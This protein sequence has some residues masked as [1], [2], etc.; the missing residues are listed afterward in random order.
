MHGVGIGVP[1]GT[2]TLVEGSGYTYANASAQGAATTTTG[3]GSGMRVNTTVTGGEVASV[4]IVFE[5]SGYADNDVVTITEGGNNDATFQINGVT[6]MNDDTFTV[7]SVT[8]NSF[9]IKNDT[10]AFT[11]YQDGYAQGENAVTIPSAR[12]RADLLNYSGEEIIPNGTSI[13]WEESVAGTMIGATKVGLNSN[14]EYS[15][16]T[17]FTKRYLRTTFTGD[18]NNDRVSPAV[19]LSSMSAVVVGNSVDST[20]SSVYISRKVELD[21]SANSVTVVFDSKTAKGSGIDVYVKT[22][23]S[24]GNANFDLESW[25]QLTQQT[26]TTDS[27]S[28][29]FIEY[30]YS[31]SLIHI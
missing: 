17:Y 1:S 23:T 24:T 4:S 19:D 22:L 2:D 11:V 10:T 16:P 29:D 31:L 6:G 14:M 18:S 20:G 9:V 5:G 30:L 21:E 27:D 28:A 3:N 12:R 8:A 26:A 13:G 15:T 7:E 25:V